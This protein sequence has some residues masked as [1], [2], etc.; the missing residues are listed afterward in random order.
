M[1]LK[2]SKIAASSLAEVVIALAVIAL[3]FG[4]AS[5]VFVRSTMVTTAFEEVRQQ[6]EIQSVLWE[7]LHDISA[8]VSL[9]GVHLETTPDEK[10]DSLLVETYVGTN[11]KIVWRQQRMKI[12]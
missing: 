7:Q 11:G 9:E 3:C 12:E 1:L 4:I 8:E 6:T 10:E 5:L 2:R